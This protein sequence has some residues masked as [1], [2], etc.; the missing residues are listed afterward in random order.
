VE[1]KTE[2]QSALKIPED[3]LHS[4]EMRL[5]GVMHVEADLLNNVCNI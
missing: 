4:A 3:A 2:V 5:P 1:V